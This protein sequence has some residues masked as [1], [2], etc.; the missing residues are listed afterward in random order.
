ME[1][2]LEPELMNSLDQVKAY[3]EADF[4]D[5]DELFLSKLIEFLT[6]Q[7]VKEESL[8]LIIDLG[9][10]PGNITERLSSRWPN[11]LVIGIDG[12]KEMINLA[13]ERKVKKNLDS[14][15]LVYYLMDINS[16]LGSSIEFVQSADLV[17]SNSFMHHLHD[18]FLFWRTVKY[19]LSQGGSL[20]HRDLRRPS[21][22]QNCSD[23]MERY[24]PDA[25]AVLKKDYLA[26]LQAAFTPSEVRDQLKIFD[27]SSTQVYVCDDR[28][29]QV[30]GIN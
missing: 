28:Y 3:S 21:S 18:P 4:S 22:V 26:S 30:I 16:I 15:N 1:R 5:S 13:N 23:L 11:T 14:N 10:G 19:L 27:F 17:V 8:E 12:S 7:S 2:V 24:L 25:P 6:Y 29:L 9:C 20:F